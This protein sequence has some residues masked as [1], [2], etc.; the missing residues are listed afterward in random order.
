[1]LL[2][3]DCPKVVN[4]EG[5]YHGSHQRPW[6]EGSHEALQRAEQNRK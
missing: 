1:M 4:A 6:R 3:G 2:D 5:C